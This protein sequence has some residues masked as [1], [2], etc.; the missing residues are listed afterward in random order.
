MLGTQG[1][2]FR[3]WEGSFY[4]EGSDPE[5]KLAAY[6]RQFQTVEI[7]ET[8]YGLP[9]EPVIKDWRAHA[10]DSFVFALK[11]PQQITHDRRLVDAGDMLSRFVDRVR[12]LED[13][14]GPLLLQCSPDFLPTAENIATFEAFLP[15]L[16]RD[17]RWAVEFRNPGW[18]S[19]SVMSM[20]RWRGVALALADSMWLR[21][22]RVLEL[23]RDPTARFLYLRWMGSGAPFKD[24]GS[25]RDDRTDELRD[26]A[27]AIDSVSSRVEMIY[28]YFNNRYAGFGPHSVRLLED[29][30]SKRA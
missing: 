13:Q 26:W 24:F 20:L 25:V 9:P 17:L 11:V 1:W 27:A 5:T 29:L 3:A 8:F 12:L 15:H 22:E 28:G 10:P 6:G 4:P 2:E 19:D 21:R 16:N 18:L 23:T 7:D 14:L 30:L